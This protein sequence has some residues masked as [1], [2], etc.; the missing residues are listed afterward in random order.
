[1]KNKH[2]VSVMGKTT[3]PTKGYNN[4]EICMLKLHS[5]HSLFGHG[6]MRTRL[7]SRRSFIHTAK[8][9]H[10]PP[11]KARLQRWQDELQPAELI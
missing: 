7:K 3:R 5:R 11:H 9:L 10:E 8:E 4:T 2:S 6:A 1:M